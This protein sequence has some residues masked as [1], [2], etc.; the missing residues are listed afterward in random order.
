[1][2]V[3]SGNLKVYSFKSV[4]ETLEEYNKRQDAKQI[5]QPI[6]VK[7][8]LRLSEGA[9][10]LFDMHFSMG[11][12]VSDNLRNLILTNKGE[13][14]CMPDF[15]A[16]L[17]GI[18]FDLGT[19]SGDTA[20]IGRISRAVAKYMPFVSLN[21]FEPVIIKNEVK[22]I[23]TIGIKITYSVPDLDVENRVLEV[24]LNYGG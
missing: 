11:D 23:S 18:V 22:A 3:D 12:Q 8:P 7:T 4:G 24:I 19:E 17:K 20:A 6:G 1:M 21:T 16:N 5:V 15:G 2:A 13:R 9:S 10:D 14:L